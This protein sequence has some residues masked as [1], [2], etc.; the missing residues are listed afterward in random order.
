MKGYII[1][2]CNILKISSDIICFSALVIRIL[3]QMVYAGS[4]AK[5][6]FK[7]LLTM[8]VIKGSEVISL[9]SLWKNQRGHQIDLPA[10]LGL[11]TK[12]K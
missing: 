6:S 8:S 10:V 9:E 2:L 7:L 1:S 3:W 12:G 5:R 4:S 11:T